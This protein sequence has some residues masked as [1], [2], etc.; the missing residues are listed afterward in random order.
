MNNNNNN[1]ESNNKK[2]EDSKEG[3]KT[4][5]QKEGSGNIPSLN[6]KTDTSEVKTDKKKKNSKK[7]KKGKGF[8]PIGENSQAQYTNKPDAD[9]KQENKD[10]LE[11]KTDEQEKKLNEEVDNMGKTATANF[12]QDTANMKNSSFNLSSYN[13]DYSFSLSHFVT[14]KIMWDKD[15]IKV[16]FFTTDK[17][18]YLWQIR[19]DIYKGK[20]FETRADFWLER[21]KLVADIIIHRLKLLFKMET[22]VVNKY[23]KT[24]IKIPDSNV[25]STINEDKINDVF[26]GK[27]ERWS[28]WWTNVMFNYYQ[29]KKITA[30]AKI[31]LNGGAILKRRS[32]S[33]WSNQLF[34]EPKFNEY[35]VSCITSVRSYYVELSHHN[36]SSNINI[37]QFDASSIKESSQ[38]CLR[39]PPNQVPAKDLFTYVASYLLTFRTVIFNKIRSIIVDMIDIKAGDSVTNTTNISHALNVVLTNISGAN[40]IAND[41]FGTNTTEIFVILVAA[42]AM[43]SNFQCTYIMNPGGGFDVV[44]VMSGLFFLTYVPSPLLNPSSVNAIKTYLWERLLGVF[45]YDRTRVANNLPQER[46]C[47]DFDGLMTWSTRQIDSFAADSTFENGALNCRY[48]T[49]MDYLEDDNISANNAIYQFFSYPFARTKTLDDNNNIYEGENNDIRFRLCINLISAVTSFQVHNNSIT[50]SVRGNLAGYIGLM[51]NQFD[52]F[53]NMANYMNLTLNYIMSL[54]I[55]KFKGGTYIADIEVMP[56][57]FLSLTSKLN[58]FTAEFKIS[59]HKIIAWSRATRFEIG[60]AVTIFRKLL[61]QG[62]YW[63]QHWNASPGLLRNYLS[64]IKDK[65]KFLMTTDLG[66]YVFDN[67]WHQLSII[68]HRLHLPGPPWDLLDFDG[69][70]DEA[71]A[72]VVGE[73]EKCGYVKEIAYNCIPQSHRGGDLTYRLYCDDIDRTRIDTFNRNMTI[74]NP[75]LPQCI[76]VTEDQNFPC[77]RIVPTEKKSDGTVDTGNEIFD[78]IRKGNCIVDIPLYFRKAD[79]SSIYVDPV[80]SKPPLVLPTDQ[81]TLTQVS[82]NDLIDNNVLIYYYNNELSDIIIKSSSELDTFFKM[83]TKS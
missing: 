7:T 16:D 26:K 38:L 11:N 43:S 63:E 47:N 32:A 72:N 29:T 45:R 41:V 56:K 46:R 44:S 79:T 23:N 74:I 53:K 61:S 83:F 25:L 71:L 78:K 2:E 48:A 6:E 68:D 64:P 80:L 12:S 10:D 59:F 1:K 75:F 81:G 37:L 33:L 58:F 42:C 30:L 8:K 34:F 13:V 82:Q 40:S 60:M 69:L 17:R 21:L 62:T 54:G 49:W 73:E 19:S 66:K 18:E 20:N 51:R 57:A 36:P 22:E 27:S 76:I 35:L 52:A 4:E 14:D 28:F 67:L 9:K 39:H 3:Q 65:F 50:T 24:V 5:D 55:S 15:L 31:E 70:F 77:F